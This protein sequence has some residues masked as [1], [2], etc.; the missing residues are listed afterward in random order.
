MIWTNMQKA[1]C[2]WFEKNTLAW[3]KVRCTG[4]PLTNIG[5]ILVCIPLANLVRVNPGNV[6]A[7]HVVARPR[8]VNGRIARPLVVPRG[9]AV[10][11]CCYQCS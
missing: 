4:P 6:H 1:L 9:V 11:D 10:V 3:V 2:Q 8:T 5:Q 7:R